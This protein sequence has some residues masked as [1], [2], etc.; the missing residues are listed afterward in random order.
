MKF[1]LKQGGF[2]MIPVIKAKDEDHAWQ[3]I[4]GMGIRNRSK[5]L[6]LIPLEDDDN[7]YTGGVL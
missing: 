1:E 3:Q 4:K 6:E 7:N 2:T 5:T